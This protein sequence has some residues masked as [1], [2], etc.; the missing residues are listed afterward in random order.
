MRKVRLD[1]G[2]SQSEVASL[3]KVSEP[4][5]TA[6]KLNHNSPTA[7]FAQRIIEFLSYFPFPDSFSLGKRLFNA[8]LASGKTQREVAVGIGS[9]TSNLRRI[10]LDLQRPFGKTREKIEAFIRSAVES[11]GPIGGSE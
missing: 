5:V 3:L 2:L 4:I 7:K 9:D 8:R 6:W 10:E 1:R 11:L